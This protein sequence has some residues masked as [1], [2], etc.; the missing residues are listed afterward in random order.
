MDVKIKTVFKLSLPFGGLE[1]FDFRQKM[2]EKGKK[3]ITVPLPSL[4]SNE[5]S[6]P[7]PQ[8]SVDNTVKYDF[9]FLQL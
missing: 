2:K 7:H 3:E 6:P 8:P 4:G 9:T 5:A 1:W